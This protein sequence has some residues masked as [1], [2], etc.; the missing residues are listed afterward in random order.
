MPKDLSIKKVLVIGSGPITI[1]QA[2]EFDYAGTQACRTL[3]AEG[4]SVVL[5]NSNPATIM[6][7]RAMAD[8]IYI[9][10]LTV[11]TLERIIDFEKPDSILPSLGGQT[12]LTLSM[13]LAKSGFLE[14]RNVRLLGMRVDTID[15]AED[16]QQFK[17]AMNSIGQPVVPS[18]VV[19]DVESAV[20]FAA[21][22]GYPV[23]VRPAF[24]LGGAGGGLAASESELRET[25]KGGLE[26]SPITQVLIE[27]SIYG[28][29]EIEFEV[30]RDG[31]GNAV[32]VCSMENLDPVGIHTGDSIVVAPCVTL[33]NKEF[34]MLRSAALDII[35]ALGIEG[36]CNCQ[37]ALRPDKNEYAVI[38][39]N[40]RVSRSS[41]LASKA[42]GY[43]IAKVATLIAL[44]YTLGEIP[45]YV[46][47][48]TCACFEPAIDY[49][50]VKLPKWPFDKFV[51]AKRTLGTQMKATGEVMAIAPSFEMAL[52]KAVRGAEGCE[53]LSNSRFAEWDDQKIESQ[54]MPA[55]DFRIF[56]L[57]E[58]LKR[59]M[60]VEKVAAITMIDKWFLNKIKNLCEFEDGLKDGLSPERY[61]RG[62]KLGY[63]DRALERLSG[64][65]VKKRR[66][67]VYKMVD[68][69][70]AEFDAETPYFY[71][72]YDDENEALRFKE[73]HC[74]GKQRIIVFGS[75][76]IRIG[77]GI[78][79]DYASVH[80]VWALKE[81]GCEVIIV[82]NNPETVST[83]FDTADRLYFEPL[84]P[85][86]V[87]N[88]IATEKPW[89]VVVAFGGQTAIK[90]TDHLDKSG[91][92]ILGTPADSIDM[93]EDRKRFDAL[94]EE[95][96]IARP[97]GTTVKTVTEALAA[98]AELGY[99]VLMRPSYVL[100]GQNMIIAFSEDDI[101]EYMDVILRE[102]PDNVILIDK[103]VQGAEIEVDAI[104]DGEDILIPGIMEHIERAGIHSG[105][106]IA[107][108]PSYNTTDAENEK[109]VDYTERLAKALKT[110]GLV[111]IQYI[112]ADGQIYVIEVNPRSSRTIPYISKV[113]G[114]PMIALAS[115]CML[116]KKL[117]KLGYGTGLYKNSPYTAVKVPIFSFEKLAD[118]DTHLGPEMKSTGEVLGVGKTLDEALY[119]GLVAAGY[120]MKREGGILITV[121]D[122]DKHEIGRLAKKY[123]ELGFKIYSTSGTAA[124]IKR[125]GIPVTTVKKISESPL[126]NTMTLLNGGKIDLFVSTSTKG[127]IP[128]QDDVKL[129]RRAT[130]LAIPCLTSI[131]TADALADSLKSRYSQLNTE[132]VDI[133]NMRTEKQ[134]LSFVK[135]HGAGND[136]I[137]IDCLS[138]PVTN[139]ESVAVNL[140]DRH[141]GVGGDGVVFI[142]PSAVADAQMRMFNAD[143][144]E[145]LMCGNAVRCVAKYLYDRGRIA[146]D[147]RDVTVDTKSGVKK[148]QLFVRGGKVLSARVD[149]GAPVFTP[150]RVPVNLDGESVINRAVTV[151]GEPNVITC[152][153]MGNPHCVMFVDDVN[154]VNVEK[155]GKKI[156]N[157][158]LFP[159]RVN[160]EFVQVIDPTHISMRVWER[161]S[162]E[163]MA[164]GTGACASVV[165]GVVCGFLRRGQ[166]VTV[167][168]LGGDLIVD[169]TDET[170]FMT[171][172]A[173]E[174]FSG[175]VTL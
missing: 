28:W 162:G 101:R 172:G 152:V 166:D 91:V 94:L 1:G 30:M 50:V 71:S 29:K 7:D 25:A 111:N 5:V 115:A 33:A 120:K 167:K 151:G 171:G 32:A 147:R 148:L 95:L 109:I 139:M 11:P 163:T 73:Q 20:E 126:D 55:R 132:L 17:D 21:S 13:Q 65:K 35:T 26:L 27:K 69:C 114:V 46:T 14:S 40:P 117:R 85:E 124:V 123:A 80:C 175:V 119:K 138:A 51:Y 59:G 128:S 97:K 72:T 141:F 112:I 105:D 52:M 4:V 8:K 16:R 169:Y 45:N 146:P 54:L 157:D 155:I 79:F 62:K 110:K 121:R 131:D 87:D 3:K 145:G 78:E 134:K 116:G 159:Q 160:V 76:P 63:T 96:Q 2:A 130:A 6:T 19:T 53:T 58:A 107:V 68:T 127:R 12:G 137:Y 161:G 36:G 31:A 108:Y 168:L 57:F 42:T 82:N 103:Y 165:A 143:G 70:A 164:C 44:G 156:E 47:K 9:E 149:M 43:P 102:N 158:P 23:I 144:T 88:I 60:S 86:D 81:A 118:L 173:T 39:V 129:R 153:S 136:Y 15:K 22:V 84:T 150:K 174:V 100:G 125:G 170:V 142:Y 18:L 77:Q 104:C 140:S 106:S 89:G 98:G 49:I 122:S 66:N 48:K 92:R 10:P 56:V 133:N 41:A 64:E 99:P 24:T 37:F 154:S 61:L 74:T 90:L 83:D 75:G 135:M 38:E 93:A 67:A 34:Q 113:T